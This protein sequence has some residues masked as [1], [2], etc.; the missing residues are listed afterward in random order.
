MF[1]VHLIRLQIATLLQVMFCCYILEAYYTVYY[2]TGI[3]LQFSAF[4]MMIHRLFTFASYSYSTFGQ[5]PCIGKLAHLSLH[6]ALISKPK[7]RCGT[8]SKT[9]TDGGEPSSI[10][11]VNNNNR[12][13]NNR[14]AMC[15]R[16]LNSD[17]NPPNC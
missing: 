7:T 17:T 14:Y 8:L 9:E 3:C 16:I 1:H 5:R 2:H 4:V 6:N 11:F 15:S 13:I 12:D 10:F